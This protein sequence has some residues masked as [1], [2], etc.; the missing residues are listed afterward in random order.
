LLEGVDVDTLGAGPIGIGV[1]RDIH[2]VVHRNV[3]AQAVLK[4]LQLDADGRVL[5]VVQ[6]VAHAA[7][8]E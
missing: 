7:G 6:V 4:P 3:G 8:V 2:V 1:L 5:A